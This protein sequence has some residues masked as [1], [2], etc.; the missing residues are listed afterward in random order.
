MND[1]VPDLPDYAAELEAE[2]AFGAFPY[3]SE[4][5]IHR[6]KARIQGL[7]SEIDATLNGPAGDDAVF[8]EAERRCIGPQLRDARMRLEGYKLQLAGRN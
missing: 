3:T 5:G 1:D 2:L 4:E 7:L 6:M 8:L